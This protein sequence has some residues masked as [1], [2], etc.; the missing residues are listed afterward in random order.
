MDPLLSVPNADFDRACRHFREGDLEQ[1]A[2]LFAGV[3]AAD[4]QHHESVHHLG[5]IAH[6][7]GDHE[8]AAELCRR[9]S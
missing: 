9:P 1:A 5:L 6:R 8:R 7:I 2:S 4:P 3:I